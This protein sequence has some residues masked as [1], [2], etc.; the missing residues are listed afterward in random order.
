M[1][2]G[3]I[4]LRYYTIPYSTLSYILLYHHT[5]F[6]QSGYGPSLGRG[7]LALVLL[8]GQ[9]DHGLDLSALALPGKV[10]KV[11]S[12]VEANPE[13]KRNLKHC[14]TIAATPTSTG[15]LVGG[16]TVEIPRTSPEASEL[17]VVCQIP[18]GMPP[19]CSGRAGEPDPGSDAPCFKGDSMF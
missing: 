9:C 16:N 12:S 8:Q 14:N 11:M 2:R 10:S 1:W 5:S 18:V 4:R 6:G 15:L 19:H 17:L 3:F 7:P 13:Q